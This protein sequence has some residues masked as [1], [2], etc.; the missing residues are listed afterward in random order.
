MS[1]TIEPDTPLVFLHA[2]PLSS[3]MWKE[4]RE[5]FRNRPNLAPDFPGFGARPAHGR[6]LDEFA[7]VIVAEM[8]EA[9]FDRVVLVGLSMGGYVAFRLLDRHPQRVAGLV[10]ADT[11]L[12]ADPPEAARKRL[13][14]ADRARAEGIGWLPEAMLP[15]VL[16]ETTRSTKSDVVE[17]VREMM[18]RADPE[19]VA[20]ALL[21]MRE[22][23][24][25]STLLK[26]LELPVLVLVGEEDTLTPI[27][28]ARTIA[29]TVGD[30]PLV[31][32][33]GA[34]HL[35]NLENPAAFGDALE[36]FLG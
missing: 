29:A 2:Y 1:R 30:A 12:G 31:T 17:A 7:D 24:D 10:L 25:S 6:T 21:A 22:R 33:P 27:G 20:R 18:S 9:G 4:Q 34:G 28:E 32:I 13:E 35:S 3:D 23:P 16:G 11:R 14:Q 15:N 5:R 26:G 36:E 19:G 8:D